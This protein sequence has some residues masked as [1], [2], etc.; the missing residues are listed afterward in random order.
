MCWKEKYTYKREKTKCVTFSEYK[1]LLV[2]F[3]F[4]ERMNYPP[5]LHIKTQD[6][7]KRIS[8]PENIRKESF[9]YKSQ[10]DR[11]SWQTDMREGM[12]IIIPTV[13]HGHRCQT[14][15][16]TARRNGR[17]KK[18]CVEL[19][20]AHATIWVWHFVWKNHFRKVREISFFCHII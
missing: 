20:Y 8:V 16:G 14:T 6:N 3:F 15:S 19:S 4:F 17:Q 18:E 7:R 9:E 1:L 13:A 11:E 5:Q 2:P 10:T 12:K